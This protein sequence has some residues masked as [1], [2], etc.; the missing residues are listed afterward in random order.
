M[1]CALGEVRYGKEYAT[2]MEVSQTGKCSLLEGLRIISQYSDHLELSSKELWRVSD[3]FR[4][5]MSLTSSAYSKWSI[6]KL[7][8]KSLT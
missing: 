6:A 2:G 5:A 1:G 8:V 7:S 3:C 4:G